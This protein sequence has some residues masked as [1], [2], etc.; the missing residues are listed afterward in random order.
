[1]KEWLSR[2]YS[3]EREHQ[4]FEIQNQ[5]RPVSREHIVYEVQPVEYIV[6]PPPIV[7]HVQHVQHVHHE[8]VFHEPVYDQV[9]IHEE[10]E[11]VRPE[12]SESPKKAEEN[13]V[14]EEKQEDVNISFGEKKVEPETTDEND[15]NLRK[16]Y[17]PNQY[18][19]Y[20]FEPIVH[21][22]RIHSPKTS[23]EP[24]PQTTNTRNLSSYG[25]EPSRYDPNL[26]APVVDGDRDA[27]ADKLRNKLSSIQ[28]KVPPKKDDE[29]TLRGNRHREG[30]L[31]SLK[32]NEQSKKP[33]SP[34]SGIRKPN[35]SSSRDRESK[36]NS[37]PS[38]GQDGNSKS[39]IKSPLN[40]KSAY[41]NAKKSNQDRVSQSIQDGPIKP[42]STEKHNS[43]DDEAKMK[44]LKDQLNEVNRRSRSKP[45]SSKKKEG[46]KSQGGDKNSPSNF[47]K[48]KKHL[49]YD[50]WAQR[51]RSKDKVDWDKLKMSPNRSPRTRNK[52]SPTPERDYDWDN[53]LNKG[54]LLGPSPAPLHILPESYERKREVNPQF[55]KEGASYKIPKWERKDYDVE[56]PVRAY[57][58]S[59]SPPRKRPEQEDSQRKKRPQGSVSPANK[60]YLGLSQRFDPDQ[61]PTS[62]NQQPSKTKF[63]LTETLK[64]AM[65][66]RGKKPG[67][68]SNP[69]N[70]D[71]GPNFG[72]EEPSYSS[73]YPRGPHNGDFVESQ[74]P[75]QNQKRDPAEVEEEL[76]ILF[77]DA[78]K[79]K[80]SIIEGY[81]EDVQ[82]LTR[83][84]IEQIVWNEKTEGRILEIDDK[85]DMK[86]F[87]FQTSPAPLDTLEKK[88][89]ASAKKPSGQK[90]SQKKPSVQKEL[91][92]KIGST[93]SSFDPNEKEILKKKMID[94]M[95]K[96]REPPR[97]SKRVTKIEPYG[98]PERSRTPNQSQRKN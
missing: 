58:H 40:N 91:L 76:R 5:V 92:D 22:R 15:G 52:K 13:Q 71:D 83:K 94:R 88:I 17:T 47:E 54:H 46:K 93:V 6:Q 80:L 14:K 51:T 8:L 34:D 64:N 28:S 7:Q 24:S 19:K 35:Y 12:V 16:P 3:R 63:V 82:E 42:A 68:N 57:I 2:N 65:S 21:S 44:K 97:Q 62:S 41:P 55:Y 10:I 36:N 37:K 69:N 59:P 50:P 26:K 32:Q 78:M 73:N 70:E 96:S 56:S 72:Y 18:G 87:Q 20:G 79:S 33:L 9:I 23:R 38:Q 95:L 90:S 86:K 1:M 45:K 31:E 30:L 49:G 67:N 25:S 29:D 77:M 66:S 74:L 53:S 11:L 43:A 48:G 85:S 75:D 39:E 89:L 60:Y 98:H 27:F 81:E 84:Q 61:S 4:T